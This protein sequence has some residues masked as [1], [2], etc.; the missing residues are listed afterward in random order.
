MKEKSTSEPEKIIESRRDNK[1]KIGLKKTKYDDREFT[2]F[3]DCS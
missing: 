2:F 3:L 1:K